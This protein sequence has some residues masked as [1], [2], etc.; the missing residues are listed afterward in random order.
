MLGDRLFVFG[1]GAGSLR[2]L[3]RFCGLNNLRKKIAGA[4]ARKGVSAEEKV[5]KVVDFFLEKPDVYVVKELE[6]KLPK[7]TGISSMLIADLV[8]RVVDDNLIH[9]ERLG[10]IRVYWAFPNDERHFFACENEKIQMT[11]ESY[12]E[13]NGR[14]MRHLEEVRKT[15][16]DS[17]ERRLLLGEYMSLKARTEELERIKWLSESH[18]V[19]EFQKMG[20]AVD[21]LR[22]LINKVTDDIFTMKGFMCNKYDLDKKE[23]NTNFNIREDMDYYD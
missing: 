16:E 11:I 4:M 6:K 7:A 1:L 20:A 8:K 12:R 15:K 2:A 3:F 10:N 14:K 22:S 19:E 17:A 21:S 23:F 9:T 5:N 13:E 18:S